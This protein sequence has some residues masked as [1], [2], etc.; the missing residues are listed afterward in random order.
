[1]NKCK[2][3]FY[4]PFHQNGNN[5]KLNTQQFHN[6]LLKLKSKPKLTQI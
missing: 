3:Y 1:M 2:Y 5:F 6:L 4:K